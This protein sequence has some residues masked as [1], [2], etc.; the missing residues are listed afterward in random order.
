M[1]LHVRFDYFLRRSL[2]IRGEGQGQDGA[3]EA[4]TLENGKGK[5]SRDP[6]EN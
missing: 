2:G 6:G 4:I 3:V 5:L 1:L